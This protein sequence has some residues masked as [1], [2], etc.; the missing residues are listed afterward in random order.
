MRRGLRGSG[1]GQRHARRQGRARLSVIARIQLPDGVLIRF[2]QAG[3]AAV[4]RVHHRTRIVAVAQ[5]QG[6]PELVQRHR[7]QIDVR[8]HAPQ[9]VN[10]EVHVAGH[11]LRIRRRIKRPRQRAIGPVQRREQNIDRRRPPRLRTL[12]EGHLDHRGPR[13]HRLQNLRPRLRR[14]K[15]RRQRPEPEA[16]RRRIQSRPVPP[17]AKQRKQRCR[18]P[19]SVRLRA[20]TGRH[21]H[22]VQQLLR[23]GHHVL[24]LI[25]RR[26]RLR[27]ATHQQMRGRKIRMLQHRQPR[28]QGQR[29]RLRGI[30]VSVK[31]RQRRARPARQ[32]GAQL[33]PRRQ[34]ARHR[35]VQPGPVHPGGRVHN[36]GVLRHIRQNPR[37]ALLQPRHD[38][39]EDVG[40]DP[41]QDHRNDDLLHEIE[42]GENGEGE[43]P[44]DGDV[45][46][47]LPGL[48]CGPFVRIL[49]GLLGLDGP[50]S[51]LRCRFRGDGH[52]R[53]P[54]SMRSCC[55]RY[56]S[57]PPRETSFSAP[58][59]VRPAPAAWDQTDL[60]VQESRRS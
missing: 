5:S 23:G 25:E 53:A 54:L 14:R 18:R 11:R 30:H 50:L 19:H 48:R 2:V 44:G 13:R 59:M 42:R 34:P 37:P 29:P 10:V 31:L 33:V 58:A 47:Q 3:N 52:G 24:H 28:L 12:L 38:G 49:L 43:K 60:Q 1:L 55:C 56:V 8:P 20:Q 26:Q 35:H 39:A 21:R 40:H 6:V 7:K 45:G 36:P 9:F 51:G 16:H 22:A 46:D 41:G 17:L 27:A 57:R 15:A 32:Q 4:I